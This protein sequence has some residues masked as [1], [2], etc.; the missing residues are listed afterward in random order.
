MAM[1]ACLC[2]HKPSFP[3][4]PTFNAL[5][6]SFHP[7]PSF[8]THP[9]TRTQPRKPFSYG[10]VRNPKT[11]VA[12]FGAGLTLT[13]VGPAS[14]A[15]VPL[16]NALQFSEPSNALSLPTWAV[17]VSS[18]IEWWA[19]FSYSGDFCKWTSRLNMLFSTL[20][21]RTVFLLK[22]YFFHW[23]PKKQI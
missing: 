3:Y 14:A 5:S 12:L 9:T 15:D 22:F 19:L 4:R 13:L 10:I 2:F 23:L 7:A 17:H 6:P 20:S 18:V 21:C 1:N 8:R 16:L 11:M